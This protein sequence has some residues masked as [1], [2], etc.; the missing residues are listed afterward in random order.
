[1]IL[2]V[3]SPALLAAL[4]ARESASLFANFA[5]QSPKAVTPKPMPS[6]RTIVKTVRL[7][8]A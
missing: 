4:R 6:A 8:H 2:R 7:T 1:M 5:H 3:T